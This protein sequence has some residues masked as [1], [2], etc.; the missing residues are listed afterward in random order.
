[1]KEI[2]DFEEDTSG[3]LSFADRAFIYF[4]WTAVFFTAV[5]LVSYYQESRVLAWQIAS[6]AMYMLLFLV[7]LFSLLSIRL[8]LKSFIKKESISYKNVVSLLAGIAAISY[9][10]YLLLINV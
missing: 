9:T 5:L 1:M 6:V 7:C 10:L 3:Q 2:L 4:K 8:A